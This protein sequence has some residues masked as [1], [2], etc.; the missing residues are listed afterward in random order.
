MRYS[1]RCFVATKTMV[2]LPAGRT[3]CTTWSSAAG[4]SASRS[5]KNASDSVGDSL[6]SA[7]SRT[8][9][10]ERSPA[11]AKSASAAGSVAENNSA[12]RVSDVDLRISW[13]YNPAY[14]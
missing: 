3:S 10:G 12:C 11:A 6:V 2:V 8:T 14:P 7:S 9:C 13:T 4:L 1:T 5:A